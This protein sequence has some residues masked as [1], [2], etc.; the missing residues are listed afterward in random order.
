[1][2]PVVVGDHHANDL[3]LT[4][5]ALISARAKSFWVQVDVEE[6]FDELYEYLTH[7]KHAIKTCTATDRGTIY[8]VHTHTHTGH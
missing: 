4:F 8:T 1:M 5:F 2:G 3:F 7:L 6:T